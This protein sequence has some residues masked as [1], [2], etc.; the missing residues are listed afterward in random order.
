MFVEELNNKASDF[1]PENDEYTSKELI[2]VLHYDMQEVGVNGYSLMYQWFTG[3]GNRVAVLSDAFLSKFE[4]GDLR[5][6][7][8][9]LNYQGGWELNKFI[10]ATISTTLNKTCE[11][12]YPVYRYSDILLLQAEARANM[13]KWEEALDIVKKIRTRAGIGETTAPATSFADQEE[14]IDYI[15]KERQIELVGEGKRWFDLVRTNRW[16]A[17]MEPVNGMDDERKV[18]F[19]IHNSHTI[20]NPAIEQNSGY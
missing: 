13:G 5:K 14:L 10:G 15:L 9:A 12:A 4:A 7:L 19:P 8:I 18:L 11:V 1:T 17:V 2:F 6:D 3:S 20:E 16:K